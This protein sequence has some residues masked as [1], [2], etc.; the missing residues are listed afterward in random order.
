MSNLKVCAAI[1]ELIVKL[2]IQRKGR[3]VLDSSTCSIMN[4]VTMNNI[5]N[6]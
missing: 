5:L 1:L 2:E 6:F 3:K 4:G